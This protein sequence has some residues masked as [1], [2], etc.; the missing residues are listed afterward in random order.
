MDFNAEPYWDDFEATNGALE[1]NYM[2]I[3]FKPGY[4]VQARE[5]TQ[6]QTILQ[7]QI[8][9]F[10]SH[11]FQD[12]SP[13]IGG[14]LTLDTSVNYV[15]LDKQYGGNDVDL[16]NF[17]GVTA[18]N[19][20]SPQS[21]A[22]VI[23]TYS[24][25]TDRT[26]MIKYI[27]G[28][29]FIAG[30]TLQA[31]S[32]AKANVTATSPTG[33]GSTVSINSGVFYVDGYFVT[34]APDTIVLDPY[35]TTPSYRIGLQIDEGIVAY[36]DDN[37]L[38]DPAQE[39]F[40]YQ[41]PGADRYQFNLVL[42]KRS[43]TSSDDSRFFE[44]LR[45]ENGV[46]TKQVSY[47]IYSELEKTFARRTYDES[48]N[49]VVKA[50]RASASANTPAGLP[51]NTDTFIVNVE[52][53][54]A[55]VKGFEFETIGTT[56]LPATRARNTKSS[57][58]YNLSI[59]FGN[60]VQL[61][62][63]CGNSAN[64]IVFSENLN[65]VDIHSTVNNAVT[66]GSGSAS[67]YSTRIGTAK[68]KNFDR[69]DTLNYYA[70]LTDVNF[71][72]IISTAN[73]TSAN[74]LSV[75]LQSYFS[76]NANA[77]IGATITLLDTVGA[78]GNSGKIINYNTTTKVAA[79]D[80]AFKAIPQ[81]N[82]RFSLSLP[83]GIAKSVIIA[84]TSTFSS[85]N[86]QANISDLSRDTTGNVSIEDAN[87]DKMLF[88]I[89]NYYVK[90]NSDANVDFYKRYSQRGVTFATNGAATITVSG[91]TFDFGSDSSLVSSA[92]INN[93]IIV[94]P[95]TG[96]NTGNIIDMTAAG[97]TRSVYRVS[98]TSIIINTNSG[99]GAS[100]TGDVYITTK[101]TN[102]NGAY[103][104]QKTQILANSALTTGDI[105]AGATSVSG[106][107]E[108]KIN[109]SNGIAWFTSANVVK[110]VPGEKQS[111]FVS[112]VIN[113][114]KIYDSANISHA[115]NTTNMI[116]ITDRYT[117]DSGQT[118][119]Y[120]NHASITLKPGTQPPRGQTAVLFDYF[121]HTGTGYISGYSYGS[122]LYSTESIPL[123]VSSSGKLYNLRDCIDLRPIRASGTSVTPYAFA[124]ANA[125]VNVSSGGY[126][127]TSNTA[128]SSNVLTPPITTGT[129]IRVGSD[130]RTVNSVSNLISVTVTSPF[131]AAVTNGT[132]EIVT[133]NMSFSGS[134]L[135][136]PNRSMRIS[137]DYYLPRVDKLVATKDKEFKIVTGVPSLSPQ[138]PAINDD[139]MPIYTMYIPAYTASLRAI[140]LNYI[141]NRRYTM[142]DISVLDNRINNIEHYIA[143]KDSET[144]IIGD[145]PKS[146]TTPLINKPIYG[147][148][149]D[150]FNDV[151]IA[152]Q[153]SDFSAS[154]EGGLLSC[155]K[156]IVPLTLK[157]ANNSAVRDK[158]VTIPFT[159]T[160]F[161]GQKLAT[162]DGSEVVQ[163]AMIAKY[164]GFVTLTPESDY[165]YSLEHQ[166]LIT[167]S[168]GKNYEVFQD[169]S[170][171][172]PALTASYLT[173]LG[174]A[175]YSSDLATQIM[176]IASYY[177]PAAS[178][179]Y[180]VVVPSY[181]VS[182]TSNEPTSTVAIPINQAG[183]MPIQAL[184][185]QVT[186]TVTASQGYTPGSQYQTSLSAIRYNANLP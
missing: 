151:S 168:I 97:S 146:P 172:D 49:Y 28:N 112:D 171:D 13:V 119:T 39:S 75:N 56:K 130:I 176:G 19:T 66:F 88:E 96:A 124:N 136:N 150:E 148:I 64:G 103:R 23:Q 77:Y 185:A 17:Y 121:T 2:R 111:L 87:F 72:P 27:R 135:Q 35:S 105:L 99:S 41:A 175:G 81:A 58:D 18:F 42:S 104:R 15:K 140:E 34:V 53:G 11:I 59:Y 181:S 38:L 31:F 179:T 167:D 1:K 170:Y 48:G 134:I 43:L 61:S 45:V 52:P 173:A 21:R 141:D 67:Y 160:V 182:P 117:F 118:E 10:G 5:L 37:A 91:Q 6:I 186:Q 8:K 139:S 14:H 183:V 36:S 138:E 137:Y 100:F 20:G 74:T 89:P 127:V 65:D 16:E 153:S 115:P 102:A 84:N 126:T 69:G 169:L 30:Q 98:N 178:V 159:E 165:F 110:T 144:Q 82:D 116:D 57:L 7:N 152:D 158:F 149:V 162:A 122:T 22:K 164:D 33:T 155:Y 154:I 106:Y 123:Y 29:D 44:L 60:R 78:V 62:N 184:Q 174:A 50:F 113:I 108:V 76:S 163:S 32:G 4:A 80:T 93:N 161:A 55:Y 26:L 120:Y 114:K 101:L 95:T 180:R 90:Y 107:T 129:V 25:S 177:Q 147:T 157:P 133:Q 143:L 24:D 166:P 71:T 145:P 92:D 142:K 73:G 63:V 12:G 51:E 3:L 47:P 54:K 156:N 125:R 109:A 46:I 94:V 131:S 128:L 83:L 70:Y 40:N 68:L 85:A 79:L 9:Q 86:L 132:I